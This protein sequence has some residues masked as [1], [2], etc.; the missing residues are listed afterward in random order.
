M[1]AI[2]VLVGIDGVDHRP[3]PNARGQRHL[4]DDP[5][6]DRVVVQA[7]IAPV[8]DAGG[9]TAVALDLDEPAIDAG[10][11]A[12]AQDLAEV[13]RRRRVA[14]DEDDGQRRNIATPLGE[15]G[16]VVAH[17][18]ADLRRDR[19]AEKESRSS[20]SH[21]S[22]VRPGSRVERDA[23]RYD[24]TE[25]GPPTPSISARSRST[26]LVIVPA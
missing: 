24:V 5:G 17:R 10:R 3:E 8:T 21:R 15:P 9:R 2:D 7:R 20:V 26:R 19:R 11:L 18:S 22:G 13:D 4:D 14:T 12:A 6:H 1:D 16:D 23:G 25:R